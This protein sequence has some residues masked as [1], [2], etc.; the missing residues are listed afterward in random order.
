MIE[1][2][3]KEGPCAVCAMGVEDC[4][5]PECPECGEQGNPKCY[6]SER[7]KSHGLMLNK[8]Q[9]ISRQKAR[10]R[11][12]EQRLVDEQMALD[13]LERSSGQSWLIT[14]LPDPWGG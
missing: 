6:R 4:L 10:V 11:D 7:I 5:C 3:C 13:M 8:Q 12:F 14:E 9:V 1:E 2:Q